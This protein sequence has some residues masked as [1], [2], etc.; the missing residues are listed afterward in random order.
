[1]VDVDLEH[2]AQETGEQLVYRDIDAELAKLG[3]AAALL[4]E[5]GRK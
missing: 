4:Q 1:M 3:E 5:I 2:P